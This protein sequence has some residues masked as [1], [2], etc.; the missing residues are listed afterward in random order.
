MAKNYKKRSKERAEGRIIKAK[1][2]GQQQ[3][4]GKINKRKNNF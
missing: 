1:A 4:K 2:K 3:K